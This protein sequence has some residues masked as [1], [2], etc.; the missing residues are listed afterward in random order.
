MLADHYGTEYLEEYGRRYTGILRPAITLKKEDFFKIASQHDHLM[1]NKHAFTTDKYIFI[2]TEA[3]TTKLFGQL[4]I[5]GYEDER[6]DEIIK[7]QWF[8]LILL[9]DIDV[10]WV[11]DKTRDFPN[12][13]LKHFNM[14]K[15]ELD[16]L[17]RKYVIIKGNYNERFKQAKEICDSAI[18]G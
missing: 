11:D 3:V 12:D 18:K 17:G 2:D 4:Y 13:R 7:H 10:E 5:D 14:I 6:V 16:R 1:L 8:D 15:D 9:M